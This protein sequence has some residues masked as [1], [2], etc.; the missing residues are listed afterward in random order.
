[1]A[2]RIG[3]V[4]NDQASGIAA[5]LRALLPGSDV[6]AVRADAALTGTARQAAFVALQQC[7]HVIAQPLGDACEPLSATVLRAAIPATHLLPAV[8]FAGFHPDVV[9]VWTN[10]KKLKGPTGVLHSRIAV[11]GYLAGFSIGET[12]ALYNRLVFAKLGYLRAFAAETARLGAV[13]SGAG[14]D[15]APL[16]AAWSAP[17]C[18]MHAPDRPKIRV[19][20]DLARLACGMMGAGFDR[21]GA[22]SAD[23]SAAQLPDDLADGAMQPVFP[24]IAVAAGVAPEGQFRAPSV[25]GRAPR[26]LSMRAY[27]EGSF[28]S[29]ADSDAGALRAADGVEAGV[30]ALGLRMRGRPRHTRALG[31]GMALLTWHGTVL[32]QSVAGSGLRHLPLTVSLH[33]RAPLTLDFP[34]ATQLHGFSAPLLGG[35]RVAPGRTADVVALWRQN[36][37]LCAELHHEGA[38]FTREAVGDWEGM[39]PVRLADL[40]VLATLV[41]H[42]WRVEA[43]GETVPRAAVWLAPGYLLRFGRWQIDLR[44]DLPA[45][46]AA[47]ADASRRVRLV[48]G[49]ETMVAVC[50]TSGAPT[51][52]Q[53]VTTAFTLPLGQRQVVTGGQTLL[54]LPMVGCAGDRQW[55]Y[56]AYD[57]PKPV[58]AGRF[59]HA[60]VLC[61]MPDATLRFDDEG[62]VHPAPD[63]E[64]ARRIGAPIS[65]QVV[66]AAPPG[67]RLR[68]GWVDATLRLF[69]LWPYL[70]PNA[71]VLLPP[72]GLPAG[73]AVLWQELDMA[74]PSVVAPAELCVAA[75]LMWLGQANTAE[76]PAEVLVP[77]RDR[78]Q[79]LVD[80]AGGTRRIFAYGLAG[81]TASATL[82]AMQ[83]RGFELVDL[84]ALTPL[85][86]MAAFAKAAWVVAATGPDLAGLAFCAAGTRVIELADAARFVPSAWLV[87]GKIGLNPAVLPCQNSVDW[88]RFDAL[89]M[90]LS[91]R[92]V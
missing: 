63:D 68:A 23:V 86:Q 41:A 48:F 89:T 34:S 6:V 81:A 47:A 5:S 19:V 84:G 64:M 78:V 45:F 28:R 51:S 14:I 57:G 46:E 58:P 54:C 79:R 16:Q 43:T 17:G 59:Q 18:F 9:T 61:R 87:A 32:R 13:F 74:R 39:L 25:P 62:A 10:G 38:D 92:E 60:A 91:N 29:F 20:L 12:V 4:G 15:L 33:D 36:R 37:V 69:V 3:V 7:D 40:A 26:A 55:L 42:D 56:D 49:D 85:G 22:D 2:C 82:A 53:S 80:G 21:A 71:A 76:L 83:A 24:D 75:D 73:V 50:L 67:I 72:L 1:M 52:A 30:A 31:R 11:L 88:T 77:F 8:E 27:V 90:M 66:L 35:V 65:G 70:P 44:H